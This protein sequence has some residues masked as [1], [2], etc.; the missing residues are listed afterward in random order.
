MADVTEIV[1]SVLVTSSTSYSLDGQL[2]TSE[3]SGQRDAAGLTAHIAR[4]IYWNFYSRQL[5]IQP[6]PEP[7]LSDRQ[8]V[9]A[10][11]QANSGV[12]TWEP[13]WKIVQVATG[14]RFAVSN[15]SILFWVY[16]TGL[17]S[18]TD[19]PDLDDP[20]RV[21]ITKEKRYLVPGF[22][23]FVGNSS[24]IRR[25]SAIRRIVRIYWNLH[26][27][28][29][30]SWVSKISESFNKAGIPFEAKILSD[31]RN[32]RRA[33]SAVIYINP[34]DIGHVA[35]LVRTIAQDIEAFVRPESPMFTFKLCP[36]VGLAEDPGGGVSFGQS[37][38]SVVAGGLVS[39]FNKQIIGIGAV[40]DEITRSFVA[41]GIRPD[42][43]YLNPASALS[44]GH[45]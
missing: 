3:S 11:S 1:N 14:E 6:E 10:L 13:G 23:Y 25:D 27:S 2:R 45:I 40:R 36:G 5:A 21:W 12:G 30:I 8:F 15:G 39:A 38:C 34:D 44:L 24:Q 16:R 29:A 31:S 42:A 18:D 43:P 37:R 35:R 32:F 22:Y 4:D 28:G 19:D 7:V 33:D 20:C 26:S 41:A 9:E 17:Q